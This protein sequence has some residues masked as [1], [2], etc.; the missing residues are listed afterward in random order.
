MWNDK[1]QTKQY[2]K[3]KY[4]WYKNFVIYAPPTLKSYLDKIKLSFTCTLHI[5]QIHLNIWWINVVKKESQVHTAI[6]YLTFFLK[7]QLY[8]N[9]FNGKQQ[10]CVNESYDVYPPFKWFLSDNEHC[11]LSI[12]LLTILTHAY[13][14]MELVEISFIC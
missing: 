6:M 11:K 7:F 14:H 13:Y 8:E 12:I 2:E 5:T 3:Q 4:Y 10:K 1:N 9:P